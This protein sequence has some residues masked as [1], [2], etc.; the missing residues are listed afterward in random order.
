[1]AWSSEFRIL[2][3]SCQFVCFCLPLT[4]LL[5]TLFALRPKILIATSISWLIATKELLTQRIDLLT[6]RAGSSLLHLWL[7]AHTRVTIWRLPVSYAVEWSYG[8][9]FRCGTLWVA[10]RCE[11]PSVDYQMGLLRSFLYQWWILLSLYFLKNRW[12]GCGGWPMT[13]SR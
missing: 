6:F 7:G 8:Q 5:S 13:P 3:F 11:W 12:F 4:C 9:N 2:W 10:L 1:M